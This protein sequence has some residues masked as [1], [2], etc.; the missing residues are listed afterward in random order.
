MLFFI[1]YML[2][3]IIGYIVLNNE[4]NYFHNIQNILHLHLTAPSSRNYYYFFLLLLEGDILKQYKISKS[5]EFKQ[6]MGC[7]FPSFGFVVIVF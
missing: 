1:R 5:I 3:L 6:R 2:I 7:Y 4:K